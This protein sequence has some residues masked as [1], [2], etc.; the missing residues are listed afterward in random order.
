[1]EIFA[2][3]GTICTPESHAGKTNQAELMRGVSLQNSTVYQ[4]QPGEKSHSDSPALKI[5]WEK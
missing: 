1:M 4:Q 2:N 5:N 3:F